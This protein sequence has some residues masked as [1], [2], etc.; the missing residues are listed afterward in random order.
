MSFTFK[1]CNFIVYTLYIRFYFIISFCNTQVTSPDLRAKSTRLYHLLQIKRIEIEILFF[2]GN[3]VIVNT[4]STTAILTS[5]TTTLFST[6]MSTTKNLILNTAAIT[7]TS[8]ILST[9]RSTTTIVNSAC[10]PNPCQN[11]GSC[12]VKFLGQVSCSCPSGFSGNNCQTPT[13]S[14]Q[15]N[16][17][18]NGGSCSTNSSGQSVCSCSSGFIGTFCQIANTISTVVTIPPT[19]ITQLTRSPLSCIDNS[20]KCP[21]HAARGFCDNTYSVDGIPIPTYCALSCNNIDLCT[22]IIVPTTLQV[23]TTKVTKSSL[24]CVDNSPKCPLHA[25]R[26]FCDNT[27]S[28]DGVPIPTYCA[29]SCKT[30]DICGNS[31]LA[32]NSFLNTTPDPNDVIFNA[33]SPNPCQNQG[34]CSLYSEPQNR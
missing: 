4:T 26:G 14:C 28:V 17:C 5:Q 20:Q 23:A 16:T 34:V 9:S 31:V 1:V 13:S 18:L 30:I 15:L 32:T 29:L 12:S 27:Y 22:N 33:C 11:G 19:T 10:Q 24:P 3:N 2:K 25:A 6:P 21:L 7:S 8:N